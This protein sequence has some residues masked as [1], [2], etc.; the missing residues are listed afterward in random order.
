MSATPS[1]EAIRKT[2]Q[3]FATQTL[4][5]A[6]L[7][8]FATLGYQSERTLSSGSVADFCARFDTTAKKYLE[9]A[10]AKKEHWQTVELL[11]QLTDQELSA[12]SA[13]FQE[14]A[15]QVG[16]MR[17]YVFFALELKAGDYS[18]S[19][20]AGM[21]RQ[22]N[23]VFSMPVLVLFKA[24]D[25]LS[26]AVINRRVNNNDAS[27]DVLEKVT[28]IQNINIA[29]PHRGH[30]D[31]LAEFVLPTLKA[32]STISNFDQLHAAWETVFNVELLNKRFYAE[33]ANWYFWARRLV[34][35]PEG[36]EKD[37]QQRNATSVIRLLTRLIF[38]WFLKEKG[39]IPEA[40]FNEQTLRGVLR[41][42]E[43][44]SVSDGTYYCAILQNLFFATLN[45][46]MGAG[47]KFA[48]EGTFHEQK[49]DYANDSLYR[50]AHAFVSTQQALA[51]FADIPFLN[52]GLFASLDSLDDSGK[53]RYADG[54]SRN[55]NQ[56]A[57]VPNHLFF[58]DSLSVD[59][60]ADYGAAKQKTAKVRGLID[61]LSSYK[62]TIAESTPVEQ[63]IAL[64]PELLGKVF[65]NLLASVNPETGDSARKQTGSF[66]TPRSIVDYMVDETLKATLSA[67]LQK[68][69]PQVSEA[70]AKTG[71]DI[72][73]AYTEREHPFNG[74]E[75]QAL[76]AAIDQCRILDPACGS[77]AFPMGILHK[78][79]FILG[80]LDP[81]NERW[82]Q[83]QLGKLDS[84]TMRQ[85]LERAFADNNDDYGRKLYLI[86]NCI[87]GVDIQPIAI[88]IA[89]LRFFISLVCEQKS[90]ADKKDN[91]LGIRPLPNLEIKFVAANT[92]LGLQRTQ[93]MGL[94]EN[95]EIKELERKLEQV[96]H[97]YFT[98]RSRQQK[99]DLQKEDRELTQRILNQLEAMGWGDKSAEMRQRLLWNPYN[100][101]ISA[102]FFDRVKMFG[103]SLQA[104]FDVVIGNPPYKQV[105]KGVYSK[106]QFPWSEGK[107]S[108]KQN[109]YK[110]FLEASYNLAKQ[111]GI[112]CLIVQSSLMADLSSARTR[113]MLLTKTKISKVLEF[114]KIAPTKAGQ[115]FESVLQGT[116]ICIFQKTHYPDNEFG[117]SCSNDVTTIA[118]PAFE[119]IRQSELVRFRAESFEF[120][121]CH[122]GEL[123]I[124]LSLF[125]SAVFFESLMTSIDKGDLNLGTNA[126]SFSKVTSPVK[127]YRG[128]NIHRY[129]LEDTV[130]D[131]VKTGQFT[132]KVKQN[133]ENTLLVCQDITG[134]VDPSRLNFTLID[135]R[136]E[137]FLF[138]D[139]V[140]KII[141]RDQTKS[142]TILAILNSR[143]MDWCF[144]KTS[145]NNHVASYE[146]KA[147]PFPAVIPTEAET[148]LTSLVDYIFATKRNH[149][150]IAVQFEPLVDALVYELYF[151]DELHTAHIHLFEACAQA[152][153][154]KLKGLQG[155]ALAQEALA[156]A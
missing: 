3:D 70:D 146:L 60:S 6:A 130:S 8:L 84:A 118:S 80:K 106:E 102:D 148:V 105:K 31:I 121:L 12:T 47:R 16:Q 53:K 88:Q 87:Y 40:L 44:T 153:I 104:G 83:T 101:H 68:A 5:E 57:H 134:T 46:E 156:L 143:L 64:D 24:G 15:V 131:W 144:R 45:Q 100:P 103:P 9:Q 22:L 74:Q 152:G 48:V 23:R 58:G 81:N 111:D 113:E 62:F 29:Q 97:A 35:F 11:F 37:R 42:F 128:K 18:R 26:L 126:H 109:L 95:A 150:K 90:H 107:D 50:Y 51:L 85:E 30:L 124:Y 36:L 108:G 137:A 28:L 1:L 49:E 92:L 54:F 21:T 77:G 33:L 133:G 140:Q 2:L 32:S 19:E 99:T 73:F 65:E 52:G 25:K 41:S 7:K 149:E 39:L 136:G 79:V 93:T 78:L 59:L 76:I 4:R 98:A 27:R 127:L 116:C 147:L 69:C 72:L 89:K 132:E 75:T 17:S 112:A 38:C 117:I 43:P 125:A 119:T 96:R 61:I 66:Y 110:V 67:A 139:T 91:N 138:G 55:P 86:E 122:K 115:V 56:Q 71:L 14:R 145:T 123:A 141:L 63:E 129:S 120:P 114:P 13:L 94:L 155:K 20:L 82:K 135:K 142:K 10:S 34:K 151:P 154:G